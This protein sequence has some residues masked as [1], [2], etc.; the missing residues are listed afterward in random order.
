MEKYT[1][2]Q[3]IILWLPPMVF[4]ITVHEVAHGWV[5]ARLGDP[6]AKLLGRLSLNPIKHIDPVGMLL[7]PSLLFF[8]G[9]F[10]FGWAKPVPVNWLNLK[11]PRRDM[12]LVAAA[13][14]SVNFFMALLWGII[15]K[16]AIAFNSHAIFYMGTFGIT[17]NSMLM[18]LNLIPI[19]P[20]DGSRIIT[21]LLSPT[22]AEKFKN[23]EKYGFFILLM[24]LATGILSQLIRPVLNILI[25]FISNLFGL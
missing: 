9:G 17:I 13:G 12:A 7:V 8:L 18:V 15:T 22:T 24:L 21:A 3:K 5:A 19:P 4:A 1:I 11:N 6:T 23:L 14:P 25:A 20:L 10:I 2:L 16:I